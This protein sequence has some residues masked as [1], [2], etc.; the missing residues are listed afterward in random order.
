M[1]ENKGLGSKFLGLFV[2][3]ESEEPSEP[4]ANGKTPAELVAELAG[5]GA[6]AASRSR[7]PGGQG[8][9]APVKMESLPTLGPPPTDFDGIF[10]DAGMDG[11]ELDQVK[12]AEELLKTLPESTPTTVKR[13][14]V[15]ASL[16][17]F[18]IEL[19]GIV[20]AAQNQKRALDAYVRVNENATAKSIEE[21]EGQIRKLNEQ[22]AQL[23]GD[24][25]KRTA[26]L[27][28]VASAATSRKAQV[29]KVLEF[30]QSPAQSTTPGNP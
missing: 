25:E 23:R 8:P 22:I 2:E 6:P 26:N 17:A 10:R 16:R 9:S 15:E 20:K 7:E 19:A 13:Q 3:S 14:I 1:S 27:S 11:T 28:A 30:F 18:G 24:I 5:Q 12:K 29:Q 4:A 21:S